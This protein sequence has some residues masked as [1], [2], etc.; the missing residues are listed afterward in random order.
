[1]TDQD[2]HALCLAWRHW[3]RTRKLLAPP[4]WQPNI[5]A[6]MQPQQVNPEPDGPMSADLA[7]FDLAVRALPDTLDKLALVAFYGTRSMPIK[8]LAHHMGISR[9]TFYKSV[10][11]GRLEAYQLSQRLRIA[12]AET[13]GELC[14]VD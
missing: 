9:K 12:Q 14:E 5:L 10:K 4:Q 11:R 3:L 13:M 6:R 2:L 7:M 1:M 8:T